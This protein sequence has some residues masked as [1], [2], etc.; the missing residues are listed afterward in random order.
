MEQPFSP[1]PPSVQLNSNDKLLAI[2]SHLASVVGV[3]LILPLI[4]Y[5]A[6]K[7]GTEYLK[8]NAREAL[9]FQITMLLAALV[10]I[11]LIFVVIGI[12]V[13]IAVALGSMVF[14]VIAAIKCS[15]GVV[16]RY[17]WALRLVK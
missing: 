15:E 2:L 5:L 6:N 1:T 10:S 17:P 3:G 7:D 16:Y 13:L 4:V 8:S 9:N 14:G 12:F 11:P